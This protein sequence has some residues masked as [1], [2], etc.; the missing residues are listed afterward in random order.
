MHRQAR[1]KEPLLIELGGEGRVGFKFGK[2]EV[3]GLVGDVI[4]ERMKRK[5]IGLPRLSEPQV[6]RHFLRLS[7]MSYGVDS[8]PCPLGSCTMKYTPKLL[9]RISG[10]PKLLNLHPYQPEETVQGILRIMYELSRMLGEILGMDQVSLSP[11]AGAQGELV[12]V[13]MMRAYF[14]DKGEDRDEII[15]PDSAHGSNPASAAM[16]GFKVIRVP[17]NDRGTV[18][19]EALKVAISKRTAGMMLTVPNT[20]GLFE[21]DILEISKM[22]HEAGGLM[23][24]DGANLNALLGR[25]RPG[26][27]GFD[28]AQVNLHKTFSAPHGGGGPGSGPV[29]AR[30]ELKDYLPPPLVSFDGKKYRFYRPEKSVGR[31]RGFHGNV[32]VL[33]MAYSYL[34]RMGR[35][36]LRE[37]SGLAVLASNYL[38]GRIREAYELPYGDAPRKHEFVVRARGRASGVA[39]SL[40][41][42]GLYPP[43]IYFPL[44]VEEALMIEPTESEPLEELDRYADALL[45]AAERPEREELGGGRLVLNWRELKA[46]LDR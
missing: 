16:A 32:S 17:S 28:I 26:D 29:G 41:K 39:K 2:S 5:E 21:R 30:G 27:M 1:W 20:L 7:E 24:Y 11:S 38:L 33:V 35:D 42:L 22:I 23:Y 36:G 3:D 13:S 12:G 34:L 4:P 10:N 14:R 44:T 9:R 8:G 40:T 6:A 25:V 15:V 46:P 43:T 31:F 37:A 18:D 19:L 45:E